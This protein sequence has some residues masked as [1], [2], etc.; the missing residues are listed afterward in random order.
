MIQRDQRRSRRFLVRL[1]ITVR[2]RD[3]NHTAEAET[4][5]R[6][7]SSCGLRFDLPNALKSGSVVQILMTLPRQLTHSSLIQV[8]CQGRVVRINPDYSDKVEVAATI[9][10]FQFMRDAES[11]A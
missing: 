4:V 5:T 7:V 8:N 1:P 11:A 2:W 6:D 10:R 9:E 3:E